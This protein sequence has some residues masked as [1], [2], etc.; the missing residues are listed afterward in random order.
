ME[1]AYTCMCGNLDRWIIY[2]DRIRCNLCGR[3]YSIPNRSP[4]EFNKKREE[5]LTKDAEVVEGGAP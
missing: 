3:E 4:R 1:E 2:S 5:L